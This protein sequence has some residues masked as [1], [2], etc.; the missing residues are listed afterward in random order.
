MA[1]LLQEIS[2]EIPPK[3]Q[4]GNTLDVAKIMSPERTIARLNFPR[5]W[6]NQAWAID[7][8]PHAQQP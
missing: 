5:P 8:G 1:L 2:Q 4:K 3:S 6:Q 7:S